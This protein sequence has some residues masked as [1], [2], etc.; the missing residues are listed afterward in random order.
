MNALNIPIDFIAYN[1]D[2]TV[3]LLAEAK[4]RRGTSAGW[5]TKLRR[6]MLAHGVLPS[7]KYFLIATPERIYGWTEGDLSPSEVPPQ[8]TID[9]EKVLAPY[10]EKFNQN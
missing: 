8:F 2:G 9:S 4:S 7:A 10:F 5:A 1:P 6:N 3:L